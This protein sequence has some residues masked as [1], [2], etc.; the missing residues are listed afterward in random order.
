MKIL[1][2]QRFQSLDEV[3]GEALLEPFSFPLQLSPLL[4]GSHVENRYTPCTCIPIFSWDPQGKHWEGGRKTPGTL[5]AVRDLLSGLCSTIQ[6][7]L[8]LG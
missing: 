5:C 1:L 3:G 2:S 8:H 4:A 7:Q 6:T